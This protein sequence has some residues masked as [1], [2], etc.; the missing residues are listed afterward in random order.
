VI[1]RGHSSGPGLP[2][3]SDSLLLLQAPPFNRI[4]SRTLF[5]TRTFA[6]WMCSCVSSMEVFRAMASALRGIRR[7][8]RVQL[9]PALRK[10]TLE[11]HDA[12]CD[13]PV[14]SVSRSDPSLESL[15]SAA[16][17]RTSVAAPL[18]QRCDGHY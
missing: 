2:Q 3:L 4:S 7:I 16:V 10:R 18:P 6:N 9:A 13:A 17:S 5:M 1:R 12:P 15:T 14:A 11:R 8:V